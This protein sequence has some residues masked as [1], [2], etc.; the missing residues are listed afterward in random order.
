M[1]L[2]AQRFMQLSKPSEK[3]RP[4]FYASVQPDLFD[5]ILN[6]C[7]DPG[8][9]C[10]SQMM[11]IDVTGGVAGEKGAE[12]RERLIYDGARLN[13][14]NEAPGATFPASGR[15]PNT[16]RTAPQGMNPTSVAPD[17]NQGGTHHDDAQGNG[18]PEMDGMP[19]NGDMKMNPA[20]AQINPH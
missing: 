5:K 9:M 2:D 13:E 7:V 10:E 12:N 14:G 20:P 3:V 16:L 8:K 19:M 17:V 15:P 4:Q 11:A 1:T 18:K 6:M